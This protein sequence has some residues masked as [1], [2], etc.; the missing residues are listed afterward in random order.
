MSWIGRLRAMHADGW[1]A[2][3]ASEK[4]P[5]RQFRGAGLRTGLGLHDRLLPSQLSY[6]TYF[7]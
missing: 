5:S 6:P 4:L 3:K 1:K 7:S 2:S